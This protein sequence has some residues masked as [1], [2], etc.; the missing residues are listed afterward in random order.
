MDYK[1]M[2][3]NR[4]EPSACAKEE[5]N[6]PEWR[7]GGGRKRDFRVWKKKNFLHTSRLITHFKIY[8]YLKLSVI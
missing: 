8:P 7:Q 4:G 6:Q 2:Q 5:V 3:H 1:K